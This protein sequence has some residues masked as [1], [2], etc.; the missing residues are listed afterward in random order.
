MKRNPQ[1]IVRVHFR[2]ETF[3][4]IQRLATVHKLSISE[5]VERAT[6]LVAERLMD[7]RLNNLP[8]ENTDAQQQDQ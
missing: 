4:A 1:K 8:K 5:F 7:E 6:V 3:A 2:Q